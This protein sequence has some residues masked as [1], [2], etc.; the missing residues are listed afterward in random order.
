MEKLNDV[1]LLVVGE[2]EEHSSE[3]WV[4]SGGFF[5]S[6]VEAE[7]LPHEALLKA[8]GTGEG[9]QG[10]DGRAGRKRPLVQEADADLGVDRAALFAR[11]VATDRV[12]VF[13]HEAEGVDEGVA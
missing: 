2:V 9:A 6:R 12:V 8:V 1:L 11:A 7:E 3:Q 10:L 13:Q 5:A 4:V